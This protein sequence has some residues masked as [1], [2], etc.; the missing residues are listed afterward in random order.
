MWSN[1]IVR[2]SIISVLS[3]IVLVYFAFAITSI[4]AYYPGTVIN[5]K[6][7]GFKSPTYVANEMYENPADFKFEIKFRDKTEVISGEKNRI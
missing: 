7:Y 5:G 1:K 2:Y 4:D 6:D 3:I